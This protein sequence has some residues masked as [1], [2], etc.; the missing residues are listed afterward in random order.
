MSAFKARDALRPIN[1]EPD[2]H[3]PSALEDVYAAAEQQAHAEAMSGPP[4][5]EGYEAY[6]ERRIDEILDAGN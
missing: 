2:A 5:A 4:P 1:R 6:V 3:A